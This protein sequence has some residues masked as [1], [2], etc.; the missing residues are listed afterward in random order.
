[1]LFS[2][3]HRLVLAPAFS[4]GARSPRWF[5]VSFLLPPLLGISA[6]AVWLIAPFAIW[7][8]FGVGWLWLWLAPTAVAVFSVGGGSAEFG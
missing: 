5:W 3:L 7:E 6:G 8:A 4:L 2:I 1:M